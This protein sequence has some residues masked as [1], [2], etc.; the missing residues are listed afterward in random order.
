MVVAVVV[1]SQVQLGVGHLEDGLIEGVVRAVESL[2]V[3]RGNEEE[4][5]KLTEKEREMQAKHSIVLIFLPRIISVRL[6]V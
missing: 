2:F 5:M 3:I 6:C 1:A 4:L